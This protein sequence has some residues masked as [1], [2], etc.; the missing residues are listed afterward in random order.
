VKEAMLVKASLAKF[1]FAA[2]LTLSM[3]AA[4]GG[5]MSMAPRYERPAS[6]VAQNLPGGQGEAA[7]P[8]LAQFVREPKLRQIL[9]QAL[10]QNRDLRRAVLD[11]EAARA[12]YRI[13]RAASL[14]TLSASAS[15]TS[16]RAI[17]GPDNATSS[18]TSASVLGLASWEIDLFGRIKS[19]TDAQMQQFL[20][21]AQAARAARVSLIGELATVYL[22]LAA[23]KSRLAIAME[24]M[25]NG[26]RV[27]ELTEKLV[28][29]GTSSRSDYYQASTVF[30]QARADV[31][32]LTSA[33]AQD[34]NAL[35]LLA[36]GPI[37]DGLLPDAL[38]EAMDWFGEVP[39]GL[40]STVLLERP[41]VLAAEHSLR[42]ANANIGAARAAFFPSLS[43]TAS[44]GLASSTLGAL[45]TGPAFVASIV[46]SLVMPLFRGG[47]NQ[48]NLEL[49]QAQKLALVASYERAIQGAFRE[50]ADA[51]ATKATIEEQLAAQA[52]LVEAATKG[53]EISQARYQAGVDTF[54]TTLVSQ[55][56]LYGAE[57]SLIATRLSALVNRV[58]LYRALGGGVEKEQQASSSQPAPAAPASAPAAPATQPAP[59][60]APAGAR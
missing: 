36:G 56:A 32:L 49:S 21:T 27:M 45:F 12:Q 6:P 26:K 39:V 1:L 13:Q 53:F 28:G 8:E 40:S 20:A 59:T 54:L 51:L 43:L 52:A 47:A 34:R 14:P 35:E 10:A 23:D 44:G 33:I 16:A 2:S 11:I 5:C 15:T 58:A 29:G 38:P 55:R 50:V 37:A 18:G 24:T 57:S 22:T 7:L 4:L 30:L 31:A 25:E 3:A 42:A 9:E 17:S 46:P 19:Q 60:A 48:A 41:D